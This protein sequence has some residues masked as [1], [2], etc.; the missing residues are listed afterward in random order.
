MA[1]LSDLVTARWSTDKLTRLTN[2]DDSSA[3]TVS[4]A[5]LAAA[6]ADAAVE[7]EAVAGIVLDPDNAYHVPAAVDAVLF[8]LLKNGGTL[9]GDSLEGAEKRF[10]ASAERLAKT[11]GGRARVRPQTTSQL[12]PSDEAPNGIEVRP[13]FDRQGLTG[14]MLRP[15][16]SGY[17]PGARPDE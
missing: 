9:E 1:T 11:K 6:C 2:P 14:T 16:R 8:V 12:T 15:P 13:D 4:T 10:T 7:F 17:Q 5:R 3:S